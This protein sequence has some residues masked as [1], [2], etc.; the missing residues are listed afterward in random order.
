MSKKL[1][2][3]IATFDYFDKT[4]IVLSAKSRGISIISFTS[5]IGVPLGIASASY[6]LAFSLT[7]GVVKKLSKITR[8]K[9][10]KQNKIL[11]LA[12]RK[13]SSIETLISQA[14]IDSVI[15]HEEYQTIINEKEKYEKMKE[16]I[17]MIKCDDELSENNK[18]IR[19]NNG[20][21]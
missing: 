2:K 11:T 8:N 18:N 21:A 15:S 14:L 19:E 10:K 17:R 13:L 16:N 9:K 20:D 3:Y 7:T 1:H 5:V 6:S 4:L 12:K